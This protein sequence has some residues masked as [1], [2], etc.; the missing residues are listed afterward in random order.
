MKRTREETQGRLM[1]QLKENS[2]HQTQEYNA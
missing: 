2:I 1:L